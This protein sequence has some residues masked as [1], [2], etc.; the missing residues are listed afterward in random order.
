MLKTMTIYFHRC[1]E[2][3]SELEEMCENEEAKI[4]S[5]YI[6]YEITLKGELDTE[7]G[8]FFVTELENVELESP[9]G[10]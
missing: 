10:I 3:N 7:T 5:L 2:D 6:G 9:I 8:K 1:K 4:N